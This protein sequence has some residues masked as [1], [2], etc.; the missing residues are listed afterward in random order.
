MGA[1]ILVC[2]FFEQAALTLINLKVHYRA[3][4]ESI[5]GLHLTKLNC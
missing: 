1:K 2:F 3:K 5:L 4:F